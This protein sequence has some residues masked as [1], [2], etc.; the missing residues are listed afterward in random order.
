MSAQNDLPTG[1]NTDDG[2]TDG[3]ALDDDGLNTDGSNR[4][5]RRTF[6][7][8]LGGAAAGAVALGLDG[9]P[10]GNAQAFPPAL[11]PAAAAVGFLAY[12]EFIAGPD[13]EAVADSLDWLTHVQEFNRARQ[14]EITLDQTLAS[15]SR[16]VQLVENKAREEAIFAVYEQAVDSGSQSDATTAAEN[17]I[18]ETYAVV[19]E[20]IFDSWTPRIIRTNEVRNLF[21]SDSGEDNIRDIPGLEYSM[22]D[23]TTDNELAVW[24]DYGSE[25][26][27]LLDGRT[28]EYYR[29]HGDFATPA[30]M[31]PDPNSSVSRSDPYVSGVVVNKPDHDDY[32]TQDEPLDT[33]T[34]LAI[35]AD[36]VAWHD[37][38]VDLY[39]AHS[40]M[41]G[42]VSSMVDTYFQP[43]QDGEVDLHN[44]IGPRHLSDTASIAEDYQEAAMALRAM[45]YPMS[46]QVCTVSIADP[47]DLDEDGDPVTHERTG[48]L[49]WTA[50]AGNML[51][52]GSELNP[53]NIVG[54][55][56]FAFNEDHPDDTTTGEIRE[57]TRPFTIESAGGAEGVTFDDRTLADA[58]QS[59]TAEEIEALFAEHYEANEDARENVH[60]TATGGGGGWSGLS[61]T[62]KGIVAVVA[63]AILGLVTR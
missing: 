42:E 47:D 41:L 51:T 4:L 32:D 44:M 13:D 60:D 6:V 2:P 7:K 8:G 62:D 43:A 40:T 57:L 10:G 33:D 54:S 36:A 38:L 28:I 5:G 18:D 21:L 25:N 61:T 24:S 29:V 30:V 17:A 3:P 26:H 52:V 9:G 15:L 34:E 56:F 46:E 59:L 50:H 55:I 63:A 19:E 20:A 12:G 37:L 22:S 1:C 45:G 27:T 48:R 14:D 16:D 39:D 31:D 11:I 35:I 49:S 58:E 23:G 53:D